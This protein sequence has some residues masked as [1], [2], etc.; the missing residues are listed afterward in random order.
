[1]TPQEALQGGLPGLGVTGA[2]V[3]GWAGGGRRSAWE[4]PPTRYSRQ[5]AAGTMDSAARCHR[6]GGAPCARA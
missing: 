5:A 3:A 2:P 6:D 1:M 4:G